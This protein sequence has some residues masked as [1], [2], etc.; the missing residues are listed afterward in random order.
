MTLPALR[1]IALSLLSSCLGAFLVNA[2]SDAPPPNDMV[3]VSVTINEDGSRTTY[4]F[5]PANHKATS[6]TRS[7]DGKPQG[8][9]LYELDAAGRFGTGRIF[10]ADG[11]FRF[12]STYK[13]DGAG[14]LQ[15]ESQFGPDDRLAHKIVYT[16]D[17][18]GKQSGYSIFDGTGKLL[19]QTSAPL[20]APPAKLRKGGR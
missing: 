3:R 18:A 12:R 17:A 13:Y 2:Q 5:D 14:H 15:E 6:T 4:E 1:R 10:G 19:G 9:I 8:K 11:K 16:Y 7:S 20:T